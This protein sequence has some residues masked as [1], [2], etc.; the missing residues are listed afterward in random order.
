[1]SSGRGRPRPWRLGGRGSGAWGPAKRAKRADRRLG[2]R[3]CARGRRRPRASLPIASAGCRGR[4]AKASGR[5]AAKKSRMPGVQPS[6]RRRSTRSSS[7]RVLRPGK[8]EREERRRCGSPA[9]RMAAS[10][11]R[12][13][14]GRR[15]E[16]QR[17]AVGLGRRRAAVGLRARASRSSRVPVEPQVAEGPPRPGP[18]RRRGPR[19][20]ARWR[21]GCPRRSPGP[22]RPARASR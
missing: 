2:E 21:R 8:L 12:P 9:A 16:Q 11:A 10:V 22:A 6:R 20:R 15:V 5:A 1:M 17:L 19:P 14:S 7:K 18:P 13:A 3:A 4:A